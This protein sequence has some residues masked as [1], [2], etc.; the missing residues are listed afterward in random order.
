[1]KDV[2]YAI[3][4]TASLILMLWAMFRL[5]VLAG[6]LQVCEE[7]LRTARA[8]TALAKAEIESKEVRNE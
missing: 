7:L 2:I 5:G 8:R 3:L 1:M 6:R 4:M